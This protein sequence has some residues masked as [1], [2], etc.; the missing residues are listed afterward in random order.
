MSTPLRER[1]QIPA[2]AE[3]P[4]LR[5]RALAQQLTTMLPQ[6]A[7]LHIRLQDGRTTWPHLDVRATGAD[8]QAVRIS[9]TQAHV[10]ARWIIRTY[11]AA[12]WAARRTFDLRSGALDGGAA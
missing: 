11:P 10:A 9:R 8:G 2:H 4:T 7:D 1:P 3:I 6:V 12:N 5:A